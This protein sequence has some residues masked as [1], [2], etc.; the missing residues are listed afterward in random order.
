MTEDALSFHDTL[1]HIA[2]LV[3]RDVGGVVSVGAAAVTLLRGRLKKAIP[4]QPS[5][6]MAAADPDALM[7]GFEKEAGTGFVAGIRLSPLMFRSAT[8]DQDQL[9]IDFGAYAVTLW[10]HGTSDSIR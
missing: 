5:D 10:P 9:Q 2:G 1:V 6:P 8:L 7:L 3:G 4:I